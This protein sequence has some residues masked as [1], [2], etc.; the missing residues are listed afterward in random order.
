MPVKQRSGSKRKALG[1]GLGALLPQQ[2]PQPASGGASVRKIPIDSIDP[3]PYQPRR[4]FRQESLEELAQSI[5]V[6]G[7]IQPILVRRNGARYTLIVGERRWRAAKLSGASEIPAIEQDIPSDRIL[8]VT[9][10][11]NIQ[12]EDLNA[13]EVAMALKRMVEDLQLSHEEIAARTGKDRTT[14][15]N[16]LRLLRLPP[17]V[18]NLVAERR[19][20]GGHAR[21]LAALENPEDQIQLAERASAQGLSVRQLERTVRRL[22]EPRKRQPEEPPDPNVQAAVEQLEQTLGTK[23]R[24]IQQRG[25]KG[26][27]E[28]EYY[29]AEDLDRI[30]SLIVRN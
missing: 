18:Q 7:V 1:R 14:I 13:I 10:V 11:E 20:S 24:L 17:E 25:E 26:K 8:E 2:R 3:N 16:L 15:T 21:A 23:V 6:D 28:I 4:A 30:Y 29:S 9:L 22:T 19:I 27:I 12:R 5:R